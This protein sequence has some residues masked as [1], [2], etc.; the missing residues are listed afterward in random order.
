M[1]SKYFMKILSLVLFIAAVVSAAAA[2]SAKEQ[3]T[4]VSE[5]TASD[6]SGNINVP[7]DAEAIVE[8]LYGSTKYEGETVRI[9]CPEAGTTWC[10]FISDT[11][12]EVWFEDAGS[13]VLQRAVYERNTKTENLLGITIS[14]VWESGDN[15]ISERVNRDVTAG[16]DEYDTALMTLGNS[17][18]AAQNG[19]TLNFNDISTFNPSHEWWDAQFIKDCTLFGE[20]LYAVAGAI[21]IMDDCSVGVLVFNKDLLEFN[22]CADPYQQVFDGT[23]TVDAMMADA[24]AC[25]RDLNGDT[26]YDD[27]DSWGIGTYGNGIIFGMH[28]FDSGIARMN[29]EGIP[30]IIGNTEKNIEMCRYWFDN[31]THSDCLYNQGVNGEESYENLFYNGQLA[32]FVGNLTPRTELREMEDEYGILPEAKYNAEQEKYTSSC[33]TGW[34]TDYLIPK[35][36]SKPEPVA[37]CLEVMSGY[38]VNTVDE[39]LHEIVFDSKLARDEQSRRILKIVQET[40][41]FDW[42]G[43]GEW[44]AIGGMG[45]NLCFAGMPQGAAFTLAS[46]LASV[47]DSAQESLDSFIEKFDCG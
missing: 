18:T 3:K 26:E 40:I 14:P 34:F 37:S 28:G 32:F 11:A 42:S 22:N 2:C 29:K 5:E 8:R 44:A 46:S 17:M 21:N 20:N 19:N 1:R 39:S 4:K 47:I 43:I 23:W 27:N 6:T 35:S 16:V 13:D 45:I 30:T 33:E 15:A 7:E 12:N 25:T 36:C 10:R 9:L 41:S 31:V 38:S 24:R